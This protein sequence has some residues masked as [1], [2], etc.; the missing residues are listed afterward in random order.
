MSE[1]V[2]GAAGRFCWVDLAA[3]DSAGA[4]DFYRQLF[5]WTAFEQRANGGLFTRLSFAGRDV[6]SLYQMRRE[7]VDQGQPSRWTPYVRVT[8]IQDIADRAVAL[9][10]ALLVQP[11]AV[12]GVAR[13][14]LIR[15]AVGAELGLWQGIEAMGERGSH[16]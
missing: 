13:I 6:G 15:D 8:D 11:F 7:H 5:G 4:K 1:A 3:R 14:A 12:E 10:G 2:D 16:G 9:G